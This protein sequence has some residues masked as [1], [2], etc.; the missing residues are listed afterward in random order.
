MSNRLT[1]ATAAMQAILSNDELQRRMNIQI[2]IDNAYP[3]TDRL[4]ECCL[5]IA[6]TM[7]DKAQAMDSNHRQ[8]GDEY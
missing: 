7:L 6:E 2:N 8:L 5:L 1:I 4:A 3:G